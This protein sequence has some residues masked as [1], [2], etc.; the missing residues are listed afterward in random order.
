MAPGTPACELDGQPVATE[1]E[2][3]R[4]GSHD[5]RGDRSRRPERRL[6]D[7]GGRGPTRA[8]APRR[9]SPA[10]R[11]GR[12]DQLPRPHGQRADPAGASRA[13]HSVGGSRS[14]SGTPGARPGVHGRRAA[15]RARGLEAARAQ[16][17]RPRAARQG[18]PDRRQGRSRRRAPDAGHCARRGRW[19]ARAEMLDHPIAG[20]V[21]KDAMGYL[22]RLFGRA[23]R[24]GVQMATRALRLALP[25]AAVEALC[26]AYTRE[27]VRV[28]R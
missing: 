15:R 28:A 9:G 2:G 5:R 25:E 4:H 23:G 19:H 26:V 27:L 8:L 21:C 1:P 22:D 12:A 20:S 17:Q 3:R 18:R 14:Q 13:V 16:D 7:A 24:P 11:A 10:L 6:L